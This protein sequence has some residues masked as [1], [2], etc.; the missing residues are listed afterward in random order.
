MYVCECMCV[1]L[2]VCKHLWVYVYECLYEYMY[3]SVFMCVSICMSVCMS[4][5]VHLID[6][7]S[8]YECIVYDC[9]WVDMSVWVCVFEC[10]CVNICM[11]V[12]ECMC[13]CRSEGLCE[14]VCTE[15]RNEHIWFPRWLLRAQPSSAW[16]AWAELVCIGCEFSSP[17]L[18]LRLWHKDPLHFS[19]GKPVFLGSEHGV[20]LLCVCSLES[21]LQQQSLNWE[22]DC[23]L[24]DVCWWQNLGQL[25]G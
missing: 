14:C 19:R 1:H 5:Y 4:M 25:M 20:L 7:V 17:L 11:S 22:R 18:S 10:M 15:G 8:M 13:E 6:C 24:G 3:V 16:R 2:Y 12:N 21:N 9:I 23:I